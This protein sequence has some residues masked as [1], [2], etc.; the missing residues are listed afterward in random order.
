MIVV[1]SKQKDSAHSL[2]NQLFHSLLIY[3]IIMYIHCRSSK[4]E[5]S[6]P[7]HVWS[8]SIHPLN[9]ICIKKRTTEIPT[10]LHIAFDFEWHSLLKF[11]C[12]KLSN[13]TSCVK[14]LLDSSSDNLTCRLKCTTYTLR[15]IFNQHP[16]QRS[17]TTSTQR[18]SKKKKEKY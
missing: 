5:C 16:A 14:S 18:R 10:P 17:T 3:F 15:N 2:L 12:P 13:K 4:S 11:L 1:S 6:H 8:C 7:L 9:H